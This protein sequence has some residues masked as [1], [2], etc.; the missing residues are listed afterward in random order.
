MANKEIKKLVAFTYYGEDGPIVQ[1]AIAEGISAVLAV[2][3]DKQ[4]TV[5][6]GEKLTPEK[7]DER[8]NRLNVWKGLVPTIDA[9]EAV[10][11]LLK[12]PHEERSSYFIFFG[13]NVGFRFAQKLM[14]KG[15][16]GNFPT[17]QDRI[18]EIDRNKGKDMVR[19]DYP[20][21]QVAEVHKFSTI[22]EAKTFLADNND[23]WVLK[24]FDDLCETVVPTKNDPEKNRRQIL[25]ALESGK[26]SYEKAGFLLEKKI[27]DPIE[28]TPEIV[29]VDGEPVSCTLDIEL[30]KKGSGDSG[31]QVGCAA[32]LV[33]PID[34]NEPLAQAAFPDKVF[35][36]AREHDGVFLWD[37]SILIDPKDGT[38]YFG[39][40]CPNRWGFDSIYTE[41]EMAGGVKKFLNALVNKKNPYPDGVFGFAVRVF[42]D[43]DSEDVPI[44][45]DEDAKRNVWPMYVKKGENGPVSSAYS[46]DAFVVTG[47]GDSIKEAIENAY[48]SLDLVSFENA[49]FRSRE[50]ILS[51]AYPGSIPNR[52]DYAVNN[53]FIVGKTIKNENG[54]SVNE[55]EILRELLAPAIDF[56]RRRI[57]KHREDLAESYSE[58]LAMERK[59]YLKKLRSISESSEDNGNS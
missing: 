52:Y 38:M 14:N 25:S 20:A 8:R 3:K 51:Y 37:A 9:T 5:T 21:L 17:E 15:F 1:H 57:S 43:K 46:E 59:G 45:I 6:A 28:L 40:F 16:N 2:I 24:G 33:I 44:D 48:T 12:V 18:M 19:R 41:I 50:D 13:I 36:L 4:D 32:N 7:T 11:D 26:A 58:Q 31:R 47:K 54:E 39:E 30:K 55:E 35:E 29:F 49:E 23:S 27:M 34:I 56:M 22:E 10:K 53:G 42:G